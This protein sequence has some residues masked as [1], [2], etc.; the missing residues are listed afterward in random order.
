M[1]LFLLMP[2]WLDQE[3]DQAE[4]QVIANAPIIPDAYTDKVHIEVPDFWVAFW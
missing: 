2:H 3:T 1:S 4:T